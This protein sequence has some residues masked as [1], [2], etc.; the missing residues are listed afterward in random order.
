M[1]FISSYRLIYS[2]FMEF[3]V[4]IHDIRIIELC[5]VGY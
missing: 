5:N 2:R 4:M 1:T 3:M